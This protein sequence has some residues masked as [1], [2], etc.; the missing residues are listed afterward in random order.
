MYCY[1]GIGI[2]D[3]TVAASCLPHNWVVAFGNAARAD[4]TEEYVFPLIANTPNVSKVGG[5]LLMT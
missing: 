3:F 1:D 2:N 5:G 4:T